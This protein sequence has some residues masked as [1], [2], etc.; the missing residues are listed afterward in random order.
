MPTPSNTNPITLTQT[1]NG[2]ITLKADITACGQNMIQAI[3][4]NVGNPAAPD[5]IEIYGNGAIDRFHLC[6]NKTYNADAISQ[7]TGGLQYEWFLSSGYTSAQ[8]GGLNPFLT[9][10]FHTTFKT[11]ASGN[12]YVRVRAKNGCGFSDVT[13]ATVALNCNGGFVAS[14]YTI[15]PNPANNLLTIA[16]KTND[17]TIKTSNSITGFNKILFYDASNIVRK[18][19]NYPAGTQQANIS[20]SGLKP[21]IYIIEIYN[22]K[23]AE[24]EKVIIQK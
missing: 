14:N 20:L 2:A 11:P 19:I 7:I 24:Y 8:S 9:S 17:P 6:P 16:S 22:G 13:Y 4:I 3:S 1:G 15:S 21:G 18:Q 12:G 23:E 5:S 10:S